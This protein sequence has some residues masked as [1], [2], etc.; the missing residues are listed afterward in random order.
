MTDIAD[1]LPTRNCL[2]DCRKLPIETNLTEPAPSWQVLHR[3]RHCGCIF[4]IWYVC[5][6]EL[7]EKL[8]G[9]HHFKFEPATLALVYVGVPG[10]NPV[11]ASSRLF[12]CEGIDTQWF[13]AIY[14]VSA[15]CYSCRLNFCD[16]LIF[17]LQICPVIGWLSA[18][19]LQK[20]M[21]KKAT[22]KLKKKSN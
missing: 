3:V 9:T 15:Q 8:H 21:T 14:W 10:L 12:G 11:V 13:I 5:M 2:W 18:A 7:V 17:P 19:A 6:M 1:C 16:A 22:K 4:V 20:S